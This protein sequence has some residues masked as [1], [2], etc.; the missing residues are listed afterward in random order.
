MRQQA[1]SNAYLSPHRLLCAAG[2]LSAF[3]FHPILMAATDDIAAGRV[4]TAKAHVQPAL[5]EHF[6][7]PIFLRIV[8]EDW[9][10]ELWVREGAVWRKLKT[11]EIAAMSGELG[12]K[13]AEGDMQAP[14]GF[15]AVVP[16]AMNPRSNYHLSFNIGYPNRYDRS[17]GRTGSYIM[18]HGGACSI[19]CFAMTDPVIEEIY[20]LINE[21]FLAGG[22]R[23]P[24]QIYPFEMTAER[25]EQEKNNPHYTFWQHLQPGWQYTHDR[26][27]PYT[28]E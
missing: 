11:Y 27:E 5:G 10:L 22:D 17:I 4:A 15:Y 23:V 13:T 20:T 18:I 19:G 28:G 9:V 21:Y 14:E 1:R 7:K 12:P 3:L 8:K 25:M 26:A 24:V 16:G 6:G 2:V